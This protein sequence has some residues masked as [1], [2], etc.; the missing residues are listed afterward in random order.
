MTVHDAL[1]V[2]LAVVTM[3]ALTVTFRTGPVW[4][5]SPV[6]PKVTTMPS[7]HQC[8]GVS[9]SWYEPSAPV[10]VSC[11]S[12]QLLAVGGPLHASTPAWALPLGDPITATFP[13]SA[14]WTGVW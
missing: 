9:A 11:S 8:L 2:K 7:T 5:V 6:G 14:P 1:T 13:C 3:P 4:I 10:K 12:G